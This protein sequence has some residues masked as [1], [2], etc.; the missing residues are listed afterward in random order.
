MAWIIINGDFFCNNLTGIERFAIEV[1]KQLD[2]ISKKNEIG[3]IISKNAK[4]VPLFKN[5][6]VIKYN[7]DITSFPRWQQFKFPAIL[8]KYGAIPL[9]FGNSCPFFIPGITFLHDIYCEIFPQD[10]KTKHEKFE[11]FYFR[12][13]Y[14]IIALRA[15]KIITVSLY[16]KE[17]IAKFLHLKAE[18]IAVIYSSWEHFKD[19]E[20][21][22]TIFDE[23]PVLSGSFFFSLGSLSKRKNIKWILE[24]A[25]KNPEALFVI[26]GTNLPTV[27][28]EELKGEPPRKNVF[29]LGYLTDNKV[30]ALMEKCKAFILPS[31]YEG[32]G[33]TP[34]EALSCG[35]KIIVADAASLPEIYGKT[36]HYIDPS[37]TDI[38][39]D[40]LL[41]EPVEDPGILLS[42]YSYKQSA[43]CLY[44]LIKEYS[45]TLNA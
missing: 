35:A 37:N 15:L 9:D 20:P 12:I 13:L 40:K 34:L 21:D 25:T 30:K 32:F 23:F 7:H 31:Y 5:L 19:I 4:N 1:T 3:I 33:L 36:A 38:N 29:I 26:S 14:R 27:Q 44:Y 10:F 41:Q 28:V 42:K 6:K 18:R 43:R 11:C 8:K 39:L 2:A 16:S 22:Y 45:K 17:Q 24:Y